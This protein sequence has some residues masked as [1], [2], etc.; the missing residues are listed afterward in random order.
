MRKIINNKTT[1][2]MRYIYFFS[3]RYSD[4][5]CALC[6]A[7]YYIYLHSPAFFLQ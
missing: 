4:T 6:C 7:I 1:T 3:N 5:Y 2:M